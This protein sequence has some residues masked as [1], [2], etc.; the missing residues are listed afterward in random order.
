[1]YRIRLWNAPRHIA[2]LCLTAVLHARAAL[3][4]PGSPIGDDIFPGTTSAAQKAVSYDG[5]GMHIN[6]RPTVI[7]SGTVHYARVPRAMW[8]DRLLR[9]KRAGM[10][11]VETY[12]F[13]NYHEPREAQ[14]DFRGEKDFGAFLDTAKSVGLYVIARIGPYVCAE[15]D[16]GGYPVW[17][18]FRPG[19][20]V[21]KEN[22]Q[23]ERYAHR[24]MEKIFAIV[25]PRQIHRGGSVILVQLENEHPLGWGT[26]MPNGY[27]TRLRDKALA[28]GL[29]VPHFMSGLHHGHDPAGDQ[30]FDPGTRKSPWLST[31]F[32][33][34]WFDFYGALT[35][36]LLADYDRNTWKILAF[37]GAG[38]N[39]Y[40]FHGGTNWG[41]WNDNDLAASYDY[42]GAVGEAGD[43]RPIYYRMKRAGLFAQGFASVLV[44]SRNADREFADVT[45]DRRLRVFAR[46]GPRG[47]VVFVDNPSSETVT[48]SIKGGG[49]LTLAP[50]EIVPL[51]RDVV[52]SVGGARVASSVGRALT[53]ARNG[54]TSTF[55]LHGPVGSDVT[56]RLA[57]PDSE[58][59]AAE[60]SSDLHRE[61]NDTWAYTAKIAAE[62][63]VREILLPAGTLRIVLL[64]TD[65]ADATYALDES[66]GTLIVTGAPYVESAKRN[67]KGFL[68]VAEW[69]L[70][71]KP[72]P[73]SIFADGPVVTVLPVNSSGLP[74]APP[75]VDWRVK[76]ADAEAS[77][78]FKDDTW[79]K[80]STPSPIGA[81]GEPGAYGW[82]RSTLTTTSAGNFGLMFEDAHDFATVFVDGQSIGTTTINQGTARLPRVVNLNVSPGKHSLAVFT[83]HYGRP[84]FF[85]YLGPI[86]NRESKG[87]SGAVT[88]RQGNFTQRSAR[89]NA[90]S[91][92]A[93]RGDEKEATAIGNEPMK[94]SGGWKPVPIGEDLFN[95]T[96]GFRWLRT[97]LDAHTL[98]GN[99]HRV[100]VSPAIDDRAVYFLNGHRLFEQP[101]GIGGYEVD[102]D[103]AWKDGGPNVLVLLVEDQ[104]GR[105]G[106]LSGVPELIS[107]PPGEIVA[108]ASVGPIWKMRGGIGNPTGGPWHKL[109]AQAKPVGVPAYYRGKFK[110]P[111]SPSGMG[112]RP[113]L[114]V[115]TQGLFGGFGWLNGHPLGRYPQKVKVEGLYL[116]EAWLKSGNNELV[117]FDERGQSPV[118]VQ[119]VVEESASRF[120][121]QV[122]Q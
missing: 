108:G 31:E 42:G 17:L 36:K 90:W 120:R 73:I 52:V 99:A 53:L 113:I 43:L 50:G 79:I 112:A 63:L 83:G 94:G 91:S 80:S 10:N 11:T 121:A 59:K 15:W 106:F 98:P 111:W 22:P 32:W 118:A 56:L 119:L 29:E 86:E 115:K 8:R 38:W 81:D 27:F 51:L 114:R 14:W 47:A 93:S 24:W 54:K 62:P 6:G 96:P 21:R 48:T 9:L 85:N 87:L 122:R 69:P 110:L 28:L 67:G 35:P 64:S 95:R 34:G 68:L 41:A 66:T 70:G 58:Q 84:K 25:N 18:R 117:L 61:T 5:T 12:A 82:Y 16:S 105:G 4:Q 97:Q 37:G 57:F 1:M 40:M 26:V 33:P 101:T 103:R 55:V 19:V 20:E 72:E 30:S 74:D 23:F 104:Q 13:W 77:P 45:G 3:A 107:I 102:L 65:K 46:K 92:K 100:V 78:T 39:Y 75:I 44:G 89:L 88:V 109:D 7:V 76:R 116:P 71:A 60:G 2:V 49:S